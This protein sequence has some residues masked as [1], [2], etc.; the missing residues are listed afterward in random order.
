M[1]SSPIPP[2]P[3][4]QARNG[5]SND[6]APKPRVRPEAEAI[7][8][9]HKGSV[10]LLLQLEGQGIYRP[11]SSRQRPESRDY[12]R[13]NV[14]KLR[15]IQSQ[16]RRRKEE[17][18]RKSNEP[19]KVLPQS[20]KYRD[21]QSKLSEHLSQPAPTPRP[22]S[23]SYLRAHSRPG[24]PDVSVRGRSL[25]PAPRPSSAQ[26]NRRSSTPTVNSL[27]SKPRKENVNF[28]ALNARQTK[29]VQPL[30]S[31]S[32]AAL[33]EYKRKK[34]DSQKSYKKGE[35]PS[36]LRS[37]QKQWEK[38]EEERKRN[39]PDPDLPPGHTVMPE[40][41]RRETLEVLRQKERD[42]TNELARLPV[43]ADTVRA[44]SKR[45]EIENRLSEIE[46]AIKIFSRKKV[47][48]KLDE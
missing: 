40:R 6:T 1:L 39:I 24:T 42:L 7:A 18:H 8:E 3:M 45:A 48:V 31:P 20:E 25:S 13:E 44:R 4:Y 33:E 30:K 2:D 17:V 43:T 46:E 5:W 47:F 32:A 14:R 27:E 26:S 22:E 37:R 29:H 34:E 19:V 36:Y 9:K 38:E 28:I 16:N 21:V 10:G 12:A 23:A 35:V 15:Q 41:E 11:P